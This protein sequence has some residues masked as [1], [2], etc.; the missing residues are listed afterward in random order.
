MN[1]IAG[2]AGITLFFTLLLVIGLV[3]F[4]AEYVGEADDWVMFSGSPHVYSGGKVG[5]GVLTDRDGVQLMDLSGDRTY[6]EDADIRRAMLHWTGDRDGYISTPIL[7][8]YAKAMTGYSLVNGVYSYGGAEGKTKLTLSADVQKTALDALGSHHGTVGVYNYKTGEL[9]CAVTTP[10][11]DP[12]DV[13]DIEADDSGDYNGVYLN[14][15]IQ[16]SYIPGSI[17]KIVTLAAALE[18]IDDIEDRTFT[19]YGSHS[20]GEDEVTCEGA[21]Y[22][23]TVKEAFANS[24][25]ISFGQ[26]AELVGREKMEA[27]VKQF[28]VTDPVSFDGITT[29]EGNYQSAGTADVELAWSGVGQYT[30][31]INPC[32]FMTFMGA[33]ANGGVGVDPYVV[34]SIRVGG[35]NTYTAQ[36]HKTDRIMSTST[37]Q[38]LKEYMRNNVEEKY[39]D[40]NFPGLTVC[41]KSGTG[42]VGDDKRPNAMFA[43]FVTDEEYPLA[44]IVAVEDAGYGS[45]VC[46]PI[47]SEVLEACKQV[48]DR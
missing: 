43:G 39:G 11:Y 44:F 15:F 45:Q 14:R 47:L 28:G 9:L 41:A 31:Q 7:E 37:A 22:D 1:R 10:N 13:P 2:R 35:R 16:S 4:L 21:H 40:D 36:T 32:R 3:F 19:C 26:I 24:C 46:I 12:D 25:N 18:T 8:H 30:D 17:F 33:I 42:E 27:Y 29:A 34:S 6:S 20:Y 23:Q 5:S 38:T 48:M